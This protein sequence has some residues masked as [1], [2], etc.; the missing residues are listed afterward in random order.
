MRR[1]WLLI[2]LCAIL[3]VPFKGFAQNDV[4]SKFSPS[5][6]MFLDERDGKV[7]LPKTRERKSLAISTPGFGVTADKTE[8]VILRRKVAEV[9]NVNGT[10]V[11][12][13]FITIS[14]GNFS[15]LKS[16]GVDIQ[17]EF[18]N[19][20]TAAIPVDKIEAIAALDNVV[21]IEVAEVLE[22]YTD[23]SR[24]KTRTYDAINNTAV[25]Q[26][27]GITKGYTGKGVILG[28]IDSGIDFRHI[29]FK[30]INGNSRIVRAY[31]L[32]NTS[33]TLNTFSTKATI[34]TLTWD[35]GEGSHGTHTSSTAGGSSVIIDGANVTVTD[36]HAAATYGGMAPEADLVLCGLSALYNTAIANAIKAICDY[37]DAQ[38]KPCVISL[39]LGSQ[40][41]PHDG[42]GAIANIIQQYAG[43]NHIIVYAASNDA[44]RADYFVEAGTSAGGG[45]YASATATSAKPFLANIQHSFTDATGN[46]QLV[47]PTIYAC[48]RTANVPLSMKFT[49][50]N[51]KTGSVVYS[52]SAYSLNSTTTTNTTL[53][54]TS[55]TGLGKY[56]YTSSS[57]ANLYSSSDGGKI[58]I[59][60]GREAYSNKYYY[61]IYCP[62]MVSRSYAL[63][64]ETNVYE[65][66][67]A[68]CIS[69]YPTASGTSTTIDAWETQACWFGKDLTLASS[70]SYNLAEGSDACSVSDDSCHADVISVGAYISKNSV[71]SYKGETVDVSGSFPEIGNHAYFSSWQGRGNGPLGTPLPTISAPGATIVAAVN[72]YATDYMND[73][74]YDYGNAR[75]NTSTTYPYGNMEGTSMATPCVSGI[76]A[77]WLQAALEAGKTC[78]PAY[79]KEVLAATQIED[80]YTRGVIGDGAKTFGEHGKIDALA[81]IQ[82]ILGTTGGPTLTATPESITFKG[83]TGLSYEKT[84]SIKGVSLEDGVTITLDDPAGIY[85][86]DKTSLTLSEAEESADITITYAP[87]D[88]GN[89][90]ATLTLS[91]TNA[92]N[93]V[94]NLS[95]TAE[96]ATPTIEAA[97]LELSFSTN[98]NEGS[99]KTFK[100]TGRFL[101]S[102]V[103]ATLT[104]ADGVF[105]ISETRLHQS[106][107][108]D[109]GVEVTVTF[110]ASTEGAYSGSIRLT[111][112]GAENVVV[113]LSG[114]ATDGGK[115]TDSYLN[116]NKHASIDDTE[117][118]STNIDKLYLYTEYPDDEVAWLTMTSYASALNITVNTQGWIERDGTTVISASWSASDI[119]LGSSSYFSGTQTNRAKGR[120][121]TTGTTD[122]S[123]SYYIT[124]CT[125][126]KV[127]G[128]NTSGA[129]STYPA[130]IRVY[131]CSKNLDGTLSAKPVVEPIF[132]F[133]QTFAV[134]TTPAASDQNGTA[135]ANFT[136]SVD[137][138]DKEKIYKVV[139]GSARSAFYEVGFQMPLSPV[140]GIDEIST[141]PKND[142]EAWFTL[143]GQRLQGTPTQQGL[144]VHNGRVILVAKP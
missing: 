2:L 116:L 139:I 113:N 27:L 25:A 38:G 107:V 64:E 120:S 45:M 106:D 140:T 137:G 77:L 55:N 86:I 84:I 36:D 108:E 114:N 124:N 11:V 65:S 92:D 58:R 1:N 81:G 85:S 136:L 138:L 5:T 78:N 111:S 24:V 57:Y 130:Y 8:E 50:V 46:V 26:A 132:N 44:Q 74:N 75:V 89:S 31:T 122:Q 17:N 40:N 32:K 22:P 121:A 73:E 117:W 53:S 143:K 135:N 34:D 90:T 93:A 131:E 19:L 6:L 87:T 80:D 67:Y 115:A 82:Y 23:Q 41:G 62:L 110:L 48:A 101:E 43:D 99:T 52:S 72:K 54:I 35:Q 100:V 123:S 18:K 144:Y 103:I 16:L 7:E 127:L 9:A 70:A 102:D 51:T 104:D 109:D 95:G 30:D 88:A 59:I 133:R 79:I 97:P 63:N 129:N 66:N 13:A 21:T 56:F 39:S 20:C 94:V 69:I 128:R 29:A 12:S 126:V 33:G 10:K 14:D 76:I 47:Y 61:A 3:S 125:A 37:A 141:D 4:S 112:S 28:V 49:V 105:E 83:Y 134:A 60:G 96:L 98:L 71:Q 91:S 68:F 142:S 42:S 118:E 15:T 119:F